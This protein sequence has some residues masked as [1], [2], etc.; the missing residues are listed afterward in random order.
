MNDFISIQDAKGASH[1]IFTRY[2]TNLTIQS[3]SVKIHINSGGTS[4]TVH[5][6]YTMQE[7]LDLIMKA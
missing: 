3:S 2:I 6:L 5:T 7:M 1:V 4:M